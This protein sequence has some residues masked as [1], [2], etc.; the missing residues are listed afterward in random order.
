MKS[1]KKEKPIA[2]WKRWAL[3]RAQ[4]PQ[5]AQLR[6]FFFLE[7]LSLYAALIVRELKALFLKVPKSYFCKNEIS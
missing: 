5:L 2:S 3:G 1:E 4:L 6:N 7:V